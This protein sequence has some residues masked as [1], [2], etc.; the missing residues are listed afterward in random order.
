[1]GRIVAISGGDLLS[2][3][4]INIHAIKLSNKRN[5][6][7]LFIGT[8]S[9]DAE[10]YL[11]SIEKEY[12]FLGCHVKGLCLVTHSYRDDEIDELLSWAD[13]IY[14][15]GGDTIFLMQIWKKFHL[16]EKLKR[17]YEQDTAVLTGLSAGAICWF[18]CGLSDCESFQDGESQ[19]YCWAN[20]MLDIFHIAYCPHYN[21]EGRNIFDIMLKQKDLPGLAMENNTSFVCNNGS[22]YF[23]RSIS[24]AR[25][26]FLQT[27]ED[28]I[29]KQEVS[30]EEL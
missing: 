7:V 17:V 20:D 12:T 30:F 11:E 23:I 26:F 25:A 16:D 18:H 14:V 4:Q 29:E 1:M 3:R 9:H 22:P 2:T 15:G 19:H 24:T 5:A 28:Q 10:G 8:A 27:K 6:N 21:E 13:V